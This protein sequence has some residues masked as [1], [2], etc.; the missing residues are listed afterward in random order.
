MQIFWTKE[1]RS[2]VSPHP[3]KDPS[4]SGSLRSSVAQDSEMSALENT[5]RS[6]ASATVEESGRKSKLET[7]KRRRLESSLTSTRDVRN[8]KRMLTLLVVTKD[9][10][11]IYMYLTLTAATGI[12]WLTA[13]VKVSSGYGTSLSDWQNTRTGRTLACSWTTIAS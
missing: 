3:S 5:R 6:P 13:L 12:V 1:N 9:C 11:Y 2:S 4:S 7:G 8:R 10:I